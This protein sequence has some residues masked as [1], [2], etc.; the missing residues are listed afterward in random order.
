MRRE[1]RFYS[2]KRNKE[3]LFVFRTLLSDSTQQ[4][5]ALSKKLG[6]CIEK[7]RPYYEALEV[8]QKAQKECQGGNFLLDL[9][10][11]LRYCSF[12]MLRYVFRVWGRTIRGYCLNIVKPGRG[13][14]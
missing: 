14:A 7:A 4:L 8:A 9:N 3:G 5:K 6:S 2:A 12:L 11:G 1:S 13:N 10:D